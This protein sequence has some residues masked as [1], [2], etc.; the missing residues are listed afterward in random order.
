MGSYDEAEV[1][2]LVGIYLLSKLTHLVGTKNFG[3]YWDKGLA[4]IHKDNGRIMDKLRREVVELFKSDRIS[5]T[6]DKNLIKADFL[7]VSFNL[8][9]DKCFCL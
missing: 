5:I 6:I 1:C 4:V 2:K 3:L 7:D 9:M 8:E